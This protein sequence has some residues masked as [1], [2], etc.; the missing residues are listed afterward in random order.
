MASIRRGSPEFI[1]ERN[2]RLQQLDILRSAFPTR[3]EFISMVMSTLWKYDPTPMQS[4]MIEYIDAQDD[5]FMVQM[6]RGEGKT[7]ITSINGVYELIIDPSCRVAIFSGNDT[8][9]KEINKFVYDIF[10][11]LDILQFMLPSRALGDKTSQEGFSI[12]GYLKGID[13][14]P[15]VRCRP[16]SG[17]FQGI[18]ADKIIGDDLEML[19]NSATAPQR[20]KLRQQ[21]QE[22]E[23]LLDGSKEGQ[24]IQL[25]GTPQ[26]TDSVYNILPSLGFNVRIWTARVPNETDIEFYGDHLAPYVQAL[27]DADP[28]NR[29]GYGLEGNRGI[30]CD[31]LRYDNE[32]L[33][34]KELTQSGGMFDLQYMLCT[35]LNDKDLYPLDINKLIFLDLPETK[36]PLHI[37]TIRSK[38]KRVQLPIGFSVPD[39]KMH[40]I[41][42]HSEEMSEYES[43]VM[44]IDPSGGGSTSRDEVAYAAVKNLNGNV[45]VDRVH[46]M[47]GGYKQENLEHLADT[48]GYYWSLS[49][50]LVVY[51]EDNFGNGM[52]RQLLQAVLKN[53]NIMVELVGDTVSGQKEL[54]IIDILLPLINSN[55]LV[56]NE[57]IIESD[58]ASCSEY[59]IRERGVFSFFHQ[60]RYLTRDRQSL[61]HDDRLDALAG[62]LKFFSELLVVNQQEMMEGI[63][64]ERMIEKYR[65]MFPQVAETLLRNIGLI[66]DTTY[67]GLNHTNFGKFRKI[68]DNGKD[69]KDK[70]YQKEQGY[71]S[72]YEKARA[73]R[74]EER[75]ANTKSYG[76]ASGSRGYGAANFYNRIGKGKR[77]R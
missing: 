4:D 52:F 48:I 21:I 50:P 70:E 34:R 35:K 7:L 45:F 3:L 28:A 44:Y 57:S 31:P 56:F 27:Y 18:R 32:V 22:L 40:T 75:E 26:T 51:V 10:H 67:S 24:M 39:A 61:S 66:K 19:S 30:P 47:Q 72:P 9:A 59:S 6:P 33:D 69:S 55:R 71:K 49:L 20:A 76:R 54:R 14:S 65:R 37:N 1:A 43:V 53:K 60:L 62:A 29:T 16:I 38:E 46:G 74:Q 23:S 17:G 73:E 12:C 58:L 41:M 25:L 64:K 8:V 2:K 42:G 77:R 5:H 36:A 11:G 63:E 13:K 15:S 68:R